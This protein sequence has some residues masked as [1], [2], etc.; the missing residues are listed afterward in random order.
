[1]SNPHDRLFR[2]V[3]SDPAEMAG[4]LRSA[5]PGELVGEIEWSKLR[6]I[7]GSFVDE[8]LRD[9]HTDLLFDVPIGRQRVLLYVLS[10]HKC[11]SDND[12]VLQLF[13]YLTR[14]WE[15]WQ[16]EHPG[17]PLPAV[18]PYV[19]HHGDKPWSGA[20]R[21]HQR[22]NFAGMSPQAIGF[23]RGLDPD[24]GFVLDDLA[25]LSEEELAAR[26][27]QTMGWLAVLFMTRTRRCSVA[28][29]AAA[30]DRWARLL[31]ALLDQHG[32]GRI[33][34]LWSYLS[35]TIE[36]E[37][38]RVAAA[39]SDT[40]DPRIKETLMTMAERLHKEG[41]IRGRAEGRA[42][43]LLRLLDRR[44]GPLPPEVVTRVRSATS[45]DL[46]RWLDAFLGAGTLEQ[47]FAS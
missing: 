26:A 25:V 43:A 47:V 13:R 1:M 30:L 32:Q 21:L 14:A 18:I 2:E 42:D 22:I 37:P 6:R 46:D 12:T 5:L 3:F 8:E 44:F 36:A 10:E 24:L 9:H 19:V 34:V 40:L 15:Y 7:P 28:E 41:M 27:L 33:A 35:Q 31:H 20:T 39:L 38:E 17:E 45:V 29:L 11:R 23:L 16:R 4:L